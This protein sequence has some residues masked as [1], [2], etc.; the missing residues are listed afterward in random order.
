MKS[1]LSL[2]FGQQF[3]HLNEKLLTFDFSWKI[4]KGTTMS[5][6][7]LRCLYVLNLLVD[8]K[9]CEVWRTSLKKFFPHPK[10]VKNFWCHLYWSDML[11]RESQVRMFERE[12]CKKCIH[13]FFDLKVFNP[14]MKSFLPHL[15]TQKFTFFSRRG[16]Y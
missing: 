3:Q 15:G 6:E 7:W 14:R 10:G 4:Y 16:I 11:D 2:K 1:H 9:T 8:H 13:D 12:R 5:N